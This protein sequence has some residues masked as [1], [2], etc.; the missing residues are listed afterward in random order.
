MTLE[1]LRRKYSFGPIPQW[2]LDAL[3]KEQQPEPKK[4]AKAKAE[5]VK[6]GDGNGN[7]DAGA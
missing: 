5:A 6:D 1:N 7:L 2:E 3:A 4:K